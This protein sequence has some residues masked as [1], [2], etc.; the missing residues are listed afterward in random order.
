MDFDYRGYHVEY[1]KDVH[2]WRVS[3]IGNWRDAVA[4]YEGSIFE[5]E[6]KADIDFEEEY[7]YE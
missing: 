1:I 6:I 7:R 3:K 2:L 5:E 4:Y